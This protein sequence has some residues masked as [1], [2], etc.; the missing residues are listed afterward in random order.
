MDTFSSPLSLL[1]S[2]EGPVD[3]GTIK[4]LR[5]EDKTHPFPT[6]VFHDKTGPVTDPNRLKAIE[7][8]IR[9]PGRTMMGVR[10]Y[11][12]PLEEREFMAGTYY[13]EAEWDR[14]LYTFEPVEVN[15]PLGVFTFRPQ[16]IEKADVVY[17]G[18]V[19]HAITGQPVANVV[20]LRGK[21]RRNMTPPA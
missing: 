16:R 4:L 10:P 21:G 8:E 19:V 2:R 3:V 17:E 6:M 20:I 18:R 5:P 12:Q 14:K 1:R 9:T 13:A 7:I 15:N 11:D